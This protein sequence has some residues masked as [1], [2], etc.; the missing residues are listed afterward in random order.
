MH[1]GFTLLDNQLAAMEAKLE[2][3]SK[4]VVET[5]EK[6]TKDLKSSFRDSLNTV[7]GDLQ[8]YERELKTCLQRDLNSAVDRMEELLKLG[9]KLSPKLIHALCVMSME[10]A[11]MND[12]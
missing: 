8:I 3:L 11:K 12:S 9:N 4:K 5:A 7:K 1:T 10:V 2:T 6:Q